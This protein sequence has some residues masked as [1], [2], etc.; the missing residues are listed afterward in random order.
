MSTK[1]NRKASQE[2]ESWCFPCSASNSQEP[3]LETQIISS[4]SLNL[5][6]LTNPRLPA[7]SI[8]PNKSITT[9]NKEAHSEIKNHELAQLNFYF[10][11][12]SPASNSQTTHPIPTNLIQP[13]QYHSTANNILIPK[14]A[15]TNYLQLSPK[16][17]QIIPN[18]SAINLSNLTNSSS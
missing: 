14:L 12:Q 1:L 15:S 18:L 2:P 3:N 7:L 16:Y 10:T 8:P 6:P 17:F 4:K 9:G 11:P 5:F 13:E